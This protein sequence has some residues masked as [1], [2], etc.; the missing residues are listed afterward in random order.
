MRD[1]E[2]HAAQIKKFDEE[3][4]GKV[5][6]RVGLSHY[7]SVTGNQAAQRVALRSDA[8]ALHA[9]VMMITRSIRDSAWESAKAA[10]RAK[11]LARVALG[12]SVIGLGMAAA[13]LLL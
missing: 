11:R 12:V 6:E 13:A 4:E 7:G 2:E 3:G 1:N 8:D 9:E 10:K 5:H